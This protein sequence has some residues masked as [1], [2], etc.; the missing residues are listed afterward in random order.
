MFK[1]PKVKMTLAQKIYIFQDVDLLD[2]KVGAALQKRLSNTQ[3]S[4]LPPRAAHYGGQ[5]S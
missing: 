4:H 3:N 2:Q 5:K 1:S